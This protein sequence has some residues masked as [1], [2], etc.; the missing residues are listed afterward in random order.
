M[1]PKC[2]TCGSTFINKA[3]FDAHRT[4]TTDG[5]VKLVPSLNYFSPKPGSRN[6]HTVY[7]GAG[8]VG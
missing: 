3:S 7:E 5:R 2:P 6:W 1:L 8:G 4:A